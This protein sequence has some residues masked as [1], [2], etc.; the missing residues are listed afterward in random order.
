MS[1]AKWT[2]SV[3]VLLVGSV[4][5][6]EFE[7]YDSRYTVEVFT[8][9]S[10]T[11]LGRSADLVFD[12]NGNLYSANWK[13]ALAADGVINRISPDGTVQQW[14][15]GMYRPNGL[16]WGEGGEFGDNLY[17][18]DASETS[19]WPNGEVTMVT[20]EG[21]KSH[22]AG[23]DPYQAGCMALDFYGNYG[24]DLFVGSTAHDRMSRVEPDSTTSRFG[25]WPGTFVGGVFDIEFDAP[26]GAYN[27]SM[28]VTTDSYDNSDP[29]VSGLFALDTVGDATRFA[30]D[31]LGAWAVEFDLTADAEF[32]GKMFII[33]RGETGWMRVFRMNED[34]SSELF[35]RGI[36]FAPDAFAIAPDGG[37][38]LS[39][40]DEASETVTI[41]KISLV[42]EPGT[43]S[44]LLFGAVS[45]ARR[46]SAK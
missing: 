13:V 12:D 15:T 45:L 10:Y 42:P 24:G 2:I 35:A 39:S 6:G 21:V 9:F 34:G 36:G 40:Y 4:A 38:Y 20:P 23:G 33:G 28:Y 30:T 27:G 26:G 44:L 14:V 29:E 19:V 16:A 41:H 1:K 22:F 37:M 8:S 25:S 7:L 18:A 43:M 32:D 3:L 31:I 17:V 46:K 11:G 5:L